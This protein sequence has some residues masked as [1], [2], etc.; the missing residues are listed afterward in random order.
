MTL[1]AIDFFNQPIKGHDPLT[2]F[3]MGQGRY[4]TLAVS[5]TKGILFHACTCQSMLL[6]IADIE[7][8]SKPAESNWAK[9]AATAITAYTKTPERQTGR[10]RTIITAIVAALPQNHELQESWKGE[11]EMAARKKAATS[12]KVAK[13]AKTE[14]GKPGA[15]KEDIKA[16]RVSALTVAV[17]LLKRKTG[18]TKD[19]LQA[20]FKKA[21]GKDSMNTVN[22]V[23]SARLKKAGHKV[24]RTKDE[25]R[26]NVYRITA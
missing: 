20:A 3:P 5:R 4:A 7:R 25:K 10:N 18:A 11:I 6:S 26:G 8:N 14:K 19:E 1:Q 13:P 9:V 23:L 22:T 2:R 24:E 12:V 21:T 17:D 15:L 16:K